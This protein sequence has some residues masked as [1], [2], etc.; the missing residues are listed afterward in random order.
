M[1]LSSKKRPI[2]KKN[3]LQIATQLTNLPFMFSVGVG[4]ETNSTSSSDRKE[5]KGLKISKN[6]KSSFTQELRK[7]GISAKS[8]PEKNP[9]KLNSQREESICNNQTGLPFQR[10][11][12]SSSP[13]REN[14][15]VGEKQHNYLFAPRSPVVVSHKIKS[16]EDFT[17]ICRESGFFHMDDDEDLKNLKEEYWKLLEKASSKYSD[18]KDDVGDE[19]EIDEFENQYSYGNQKKTS[20]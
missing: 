19:D 3:K 8:I 20:K 10:R 1:N 17:G 5:N 18:Y 13:P 15:K 11:A 7:L 16:K 6:Q 12:R 4:N 9:L 14:L 2:V